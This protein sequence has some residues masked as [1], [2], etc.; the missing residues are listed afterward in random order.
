MLCSIIY[1][2]NIP[3]HYYVMKKVLWHHLNQ[4]HWIQINLTSLTSDIN[5]R[6]VTT[7]NSQIAFDSDAM[8]SKT[9]WHPIITLEEKPL[10]RLSHMV[11]KAEVWKF[12]SFRCF[13]QS[14]LPSI[15]GKKIQHHLMCQL[16]SVSIRLQLRYGTVGHV[17]LIWEFNGL[18]ALSKQ[19]VLSSS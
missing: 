2:T 18:F 11:W 12:P 19:Q 5:R 7:V 13:C 16:V 1:M 4:L 10:I 8:H 14:V 3:Q 9:S 6:A 15:N 17:L